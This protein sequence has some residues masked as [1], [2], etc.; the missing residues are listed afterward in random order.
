MPKA[1]RFDHYGGRDVLYI[2]EVEKP[3]PAPDEVLV[4]V[5]AA[6]INPGESAIREGRSGRSLSGHLSL[7]A[8]Q[9]PRRRRGRDRERCRQVRIRT[10]GAR[11]VRPAIEPGDR[12]R[13]HGGASD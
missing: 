11:L 4:A 13:R 10:G 9:R 2:A 12:R 8:G 7:R 6:G 1:V 3:I 5:R